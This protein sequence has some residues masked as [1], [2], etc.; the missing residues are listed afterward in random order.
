MKKINILFILPKAQQGGA[1]QQVLYLIKGLDKTLF[2][3]HLGFLYP[4]EEM[5]SDFEK[6]KSIKLIQFNK[7]NSL[8]ATIFFKISRYIK[9][10]KI[11]V[12]HAFLGNHHAYLPAM[13]SQKAI[14]VGGIMDSRYKEL[15]TI[16]KIKK[17]KIGKLISK[18]AK[19][20]LVSCSNAGRQIYLTKGYN[21]K[22]V[23]FIP[24][25]IDYKKY[26]KG[27]STKIEHEF[28]LNKK[29]VLSTVGRLIKSKNHKALIEI[30]E[31][32]TLKHKDI[33]LLIIGDGPE[34]LNLKKLVKA[35]N[36]SNRIIF[37][38]NR[39]DIPD[40]LAATDIFV[41]TSLTEGWP[42]VIGEAMSAGVP[43]V[44]YNVGD[45]KQ[46]ITNE[47]DGYI[48]EN[49][50][51]SFLQLIEKLKKSRKLRAQIGL[52]AKKTIKNNYSVEKFIERY[53]Q[54]YTNLLLKRNN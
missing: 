37:T 29:F 53:E 40:L 42:N 4:C 30:M 47:V 24:N 8:D 12:V 52:N 7:K 25:G 19:Y 51:S 10:Q 31:T 26:V 23:F 39:K 6:I 5:Y 54:F 15:S 17:F 20:Y 14:S 34:L 3:V 41:F 18:Y 28:N 45:V 32:L 46:I 11:D 44:T 33:I 50:K 16:S 35:K 36:L 43:V 38:G 13:L 1:E 9:A 27:N 49:D 21:Q 48:I 22:S 2:N